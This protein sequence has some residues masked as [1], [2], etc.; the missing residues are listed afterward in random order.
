MIDPT[1]RPWLL[2]GHHSALITL[3]LVQL[4]GLA[5]YSVSVIVEKDFTSQSWPEFYQHLE[6]EKMIYLPPEIRNSKMPLQQKLKFL[7]NDLFDLNKK[8][9]FMRS[10]LGTAF[11]EIDISGKDLVR[12]IEFYLAEII[13]KDV[14]L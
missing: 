9:D 2:D 11:K 7:A 10:L 8:D 1:G 14:S 4:A 5:S 6:K 3:R 12:Y 13:I